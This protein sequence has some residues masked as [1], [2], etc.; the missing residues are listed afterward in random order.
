MYTFTCF[1]LLDMASSLVF[2][3]KIY[4]IV[5]FLSNKKEKRRKWRAGWCRFSSVMEEE[6]EDVWCKNC[7][8]SDERS[9]VQ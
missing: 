1:E 7:S 9:D 2:V 4:N 5:T 8:F 6:D 3:L